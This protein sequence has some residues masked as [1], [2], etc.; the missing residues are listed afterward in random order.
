[1]F[2]EVF[3]CSRIYQILINFLFLY[4]DLLTIDPHTPTPEPI[5]YDKTDGQWYNHDG[6]DIKKTQSRK[7]SCMAQ[8]VYVVTLFQ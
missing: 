3:L 8:Q 1:M 4:S 2:Y 5:R 7:G 6:V